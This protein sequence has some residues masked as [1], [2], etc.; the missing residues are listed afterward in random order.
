M[1]EPAAPTFIA[2]VN[3]GKLARWLRVMG[4]DTLMFEGTED[5]D[6]VRA[7][8]A[9]GRI[10]LTRD[11]HIASRRLV[12]EGRLKA[13]LITSDNLDDQVRQVVRELGLPHDFRPF[14]RCLECNQP[15]V[16]RTPEEVRERVPPYVFRTQTGYME[17][18]RCHR[19]Y[20]RGTHWQAMTD[21]L[22]RTLADAP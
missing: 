12:R 7:A 4:F 5:S 2:D 17:C 18:P 9:G 16:E 20:W 1:A 6:L 13:V 11:S 15:L 19:I 14:T 8:L 21:R 10:I 3:V 22:K